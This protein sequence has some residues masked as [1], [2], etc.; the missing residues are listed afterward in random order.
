MKEHKNVLPSGVEIVVRGMKGADKDLIAKGKTGY[1]KLLASCIISLGDKDTIGE[2]DVKNML[3]VDRSYTLFLIRQT[4]FDFPETFDFDHI[5]SIEASGRTHKR[6]TQQ[7]M[8]LGEVNFNLKPYS[9]YA[10][11]LKGLYKD[12]AN[13]EE[14]EVMY[15]YYTEMLEKHKLFEMQLGISGKKVQLELLDGNLEHKFGAIKE[16]KPDFA[17]QYRNPKV[18]EDSKDET[19]K[20][21]WF[22]FLFDNIDGKDIAQMAG[23]IY[24]R[25]ADFDLI[26]RLD[27][28]DEAGNLPPKSEKVGLFQLPFL[29]PRQV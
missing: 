15:T 18:W 26:V 14:R 12:Y 7:S 19:K 28:E 29:S 21:S 13:I 17:V 4:T 25:E 9:F 8:D 23:E 16:P 5:F 22:P 11:H 3:T 10:E 24:K 6:K 2:K 20:G 1:D 27:F